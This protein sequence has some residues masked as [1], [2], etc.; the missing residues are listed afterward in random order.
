MAPPTAQLALALSP[1]AAQCSALGIKLVRCKCGLSAC[2]VWCGY[3]GNAW[4]AVAHS[5]DAC[6]KL[7]LERVKPSETLTPPTAL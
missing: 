2:A 5:L 3:A 7:A 6:A 4:I 1:A